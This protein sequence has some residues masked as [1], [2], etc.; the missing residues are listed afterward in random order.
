MSKLIFNIVD[1]NVKKIHRVLSAYLDLKM[2]NVPKK[3][4]KLVKFSMTYARNRCP[5]LDVYGSLICIFQFREKAI[6][7]QN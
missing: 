1:D 7:M 6:L 3:K 5:F 4:K 2:V